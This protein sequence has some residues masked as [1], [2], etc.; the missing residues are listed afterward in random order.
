MFSVHIQ[1]ELNTDFYNMNSANVQIRRS[2]LERKKNL[3]QKV[4]PTA[5]PRKYT[6]CLEKT[7]KY[8]QNNVCAGKM[9]REKACVID[10]SRKSS[11]R[12]LRVFNPIYFEVFNSAGKQLM[13]WVDQKRIPQK[14]ALAQFSLL[15]NLWRVTDEY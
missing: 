11:R 10:R 1:M 3:H 5:L 8:H 9:V 2:V 6:A 15:P 4:S 7:P 13:A 14:H 12:N